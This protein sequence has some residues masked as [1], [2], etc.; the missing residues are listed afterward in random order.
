MSDYLDNLI[1]K[2]LGLAEVVA[3]RPTSLFEPLRSEA[4]PLVHEYHSSD[5]DVAPRRTPAGADHLMDVAAPAQ[6]EDLSSE[7]APPQLRAAQT[8]RPSQH[9][10]Q[11]TVQSVD[12]VASRPEPWLTPNQPVSVEAGQRADRALSATPPTQQPGD[13]QMVDSHQAAPVHASSLIVS[14][15]TIPA[16]PQV[17]GAPEA[18][19]F[20]PAQASRAPVTTT[21]PSGAKLVAPMSLRRADQERV[22]ASPDRA[23][24]PTPAAD[25][26]APTIKIT[27]GRVDVRAV[28]PD[29]ESP[30]PAAPAR[31]HALTLEEYL[32]RRSGG[33]I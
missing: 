3:P 31:N 33:K 14:H 7:D 16:G 13:Q 20:A 15:A 23:A 24:I 22:S 26:A 30:R 19:P 8:D 18:E 25:A 9:L 17:P 5:Q 11:S 2:S 6:S 12:R 4:G 21:S 28:T 10:V 29:K 1:A 27:I 32:K